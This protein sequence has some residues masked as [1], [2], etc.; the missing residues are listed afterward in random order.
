[1]ATET[2]TRT[3]RTTTT[4][5][6]LAT[7]A[8]VGIL[9]TGAVVPAASAQ[10]LTGPGALLDEVLAEDGQTGSNGGTGRGS[11]GERITDGPETTRETTTQTEDQSE[12]NTQ[13][14][15][16]NIEQ[17]ANNNA[18]TGSGDG[19]EVA[20][21]ANS[22]SDSECKIKDKSKDHKDKSKDDKDKSKDDRYESRHD[23]SGHP[24][25]CNSTSES[26]SAVSTTAV[27]EQNQTVDRPTL[28][29]TN[30]AGTDES[31]SAVVGF[32]LGFESFT[33]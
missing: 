30:D 29:N 24:I 26:S 14:N 20:S 4:A 28:V 17:T 11:D 10:L 15:A 12:Q 19:S 23:G 2:T 5:L 7:F 6:I 13:T 3:T 1:M 32:D 18:Q 9:T 25:E 16:L 27:Q 33:N 31:R 21:A 22:E 8:L